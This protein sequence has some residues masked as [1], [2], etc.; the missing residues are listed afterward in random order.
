VH[1]VVA[2]LGNPLWKA[3]VSSR[4]GNIIRKPLPLDLDAVVKYLSKRKRN[5]ITDKTQAEME[6]KKS[7]T[8][9]LRTEGR[10]AGELVKELNTEGDFFERKRQEW[11]DGGKKGDPKD[12]PAY[13]ARGYNGEPS[14]FQTMMNVCKC[15]EKGCLSDCRPV[16]QL[17]IDIG[18]P[19][20][21]TGLQHRIKKSES[22]KN[23]TFHR[24]ANLLVAQASRAPPS[25]CT[26]A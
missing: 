25:P 10:S 19:R 4:L 5:P 1:E 12:R 15:A 11:A 7:F 26:S 2:T 22:V 21:V 14:T 6:A 16:E 13:R 18:P 8:V 9:S 20:P 23:E 17:Y 24:I 3:T